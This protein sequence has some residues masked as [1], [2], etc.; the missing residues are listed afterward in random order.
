MT[1]QTTY[2]STHQG[3]RDLD[4]PPRGGAVTVGPP[5]AVETAARGEGTRINVGPTERAASVLAGGLVVGYGL[6]RRDLAGL[7]IA[8]LATGLICRGIV[9]HCAVYEAAGINTAR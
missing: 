9:G 5:E 6:G 2:R 3:V 7:L 1:A 4:H 8:A